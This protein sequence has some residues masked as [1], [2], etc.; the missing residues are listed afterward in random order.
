MKK[1]IGFAAL[2]FVL[3]LVLTGC[4]ARSVEEM[5]ALPK[6][7]RE[8][9]QMQTA[10]DA[11]MEGLAYSAPRSGENQQTVQMADLDGDG[12]DEILVFA[13]GGWD[14]P[15]QV[16]IFK[17]SPDGKVR[18]M[19]NIGF[20]GLEFE[21]VEYV[22]FDE[23]PGFELVIG[24]RIGEQVLR[25]VA[26]YSFSEGTAELLLLNSYSKF[27]TC[28]LD[29]DGRGELMVL[30]PGEAETQRGMAVL[31]SYR[32]GQVV[33]SVETELSQDTVHI[34]RIVSGNLEDGAAA[35]FVASAVDENAIV[36][37]IFT[38]CQNRF[39]NI[40]FSDQASTSIETLRNYYVYCE[41]IDGD[42][43]LELPSMIP[44]E[45]V[46]TQQGKAERFL[47]RWF[48]L[49]SR[50]TSEDKLFT[51]HNFEGGWY[52]RLGKEWAGRVSAN[53]DEGV[54]RF[55]LWDERFDLAQELFNVYVFT[56]SDRDEAAS[57]EGRFPL[58]RAEGIAYAGEL[59]QAAMELGLTQERLT[60]AFQ[61]IR[62]D[63]KTG[64]TG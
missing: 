22:D 32:D 23:K 4:A 41:D 10:I 40:A 53:L 8:Y 5:Y 60:Q 15:L 59:R 58:Y 37:D 51:F 46:S 6:R 52:L 55:F 36:T 43:V 39:T 18:K 64:E 1:R 27:V 26:V 50:G 62:Q 35:V 45:Q 38:M 17:Q 49:S 12:S 21:Q 30:R 44:M 29:R 54:Y 2:A 33:R 42:G 16:L 11:A 48:S 61:L 31:Y 47:L 25:S 24:Q 63:W 57:A 28:D 7:S 19:E 3:A 56:G 9:R 20:E 14:R 34:K 13:K